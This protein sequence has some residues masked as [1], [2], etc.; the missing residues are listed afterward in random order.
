[1]PEPDDEQVEAARRRKIAQ[2][3]GRSGRASTIMTDFGNDRG[4][5]QKLGG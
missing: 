3:M 4:G 5:G 2:Q 1:M